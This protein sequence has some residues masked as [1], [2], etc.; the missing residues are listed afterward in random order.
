MYGGRLHPGAIAYIK[1]LPKEKREEWLE[2]L[3][4]AIENNAKKENK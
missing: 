4:I 1:S 3:R 2:K